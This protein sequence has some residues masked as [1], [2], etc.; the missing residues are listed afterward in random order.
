MVGVM[1]APKPERF[2]QEL[3]DLLEL[4]GELRDAYLWLW[5][6]GYERSRAGDGIQVA[7]SGHSDPTAGTV[8]DGRITGNG[9]YFDGEH[10]QARARCQNAARHVRDALG[11]LRGARG[12]LSRIG[13]R[14]ERVMDGPELA[15][16]RM[17]SNELALVRAAKQ[18]RTERGEGWGNA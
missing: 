8:I 11:H 13:Q 5:P 2:N 10:S 17:P 15:G 12:E 3:A 7:T 18:R 16:D 6:I 14:G 4:A 9:D 1:T